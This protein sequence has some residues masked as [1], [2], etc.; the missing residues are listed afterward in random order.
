MIPI[1]IFI[2]VPIY[3]AL[4][5][6]LGYMAAEHDARG[7]RE[8]ELN[9]LNGILKINEDE[10][11]DLLKS[12]RITYE[13]EIR[14]INQRNA[15]LLNETSHITGVDKIDLPSFGTIYLDSEKHLREAMR[16]L[17]EED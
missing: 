10:Y 9:S 16:L 1:G 7:R 2:A 14:E 11:K 15:R 17:N 13:T 6:L 3:T 4:V 8:K 12:T 5:F